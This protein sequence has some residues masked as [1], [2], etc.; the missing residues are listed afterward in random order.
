L[1]FK[2][3]NVQKYTG[4]ILYTGKFTFSWIPNFVDEIVKRKYNKCLYYFK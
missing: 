2:A 4:S 1:Y 3:E